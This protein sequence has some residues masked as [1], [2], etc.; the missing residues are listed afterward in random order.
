MLKE[1]KAFAM[2]GNVIDMAVGIVIGA[3]FKDIVTS[4]VSNII[5]P[6]IALLGDMPFKQWAYTLREAANPQ[7]NIAIT[8]GQ[9]LDTIFSFVIV[10][11][12]IFILVKVMNRAQDLL[13]GDDEE[14][15]K[16]PTTKNCEYCLSK[17]AIAATRCPCCT[18]H[19]VSEPA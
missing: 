10:A 1:F 12:A 5:T 2:R 13:D 9:F 18:S 6:P 17:I 14:E 8:Y 4:L 3:A 15:E 7:E 11:F 19:I 16:E